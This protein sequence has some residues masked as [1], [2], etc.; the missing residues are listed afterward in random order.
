MDS[1]HLPGPTSF[2]GM[3]TELIARGPQPKQPQAEAEEAGREE[4]KQNVLTCPK[5][6]TEFSEEHQGELLAHMDVCWE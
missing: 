6:N 5:C 4:T 3:G 2:H 1:A